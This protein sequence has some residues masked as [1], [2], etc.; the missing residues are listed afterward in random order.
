VATADW[1]YLGLRARGYSD[2][3]LSVGLA[4]VRRVADGWRGAF[5][6]FEHEEKGT[7]PALARR[8]LARLAA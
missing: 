4:T 7:G 3:D 1:G 5:V 2:D 6:F 8:L